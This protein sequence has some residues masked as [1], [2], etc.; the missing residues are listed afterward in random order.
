MMPGPTHSVQQAIDPLL[1][2][3]ASL[4]HRDEISRALA[5]GQRNRVPQLAQFRC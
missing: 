2:L 3:K 5:E 4:E 1:A